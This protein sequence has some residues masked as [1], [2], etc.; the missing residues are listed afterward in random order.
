M[1]SDLFA[2]PGQ[3]IELRVNRS[4]VAI[5]SSHVNIVDVMDDPCLQGLILLLGTCVRTYLETNVLMLDM[6]VRH[7][8][9]IFYVQ[10]KL[11]SR[12]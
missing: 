11:T 4:I 3:S 10:F 12:V 9:R 2:R 8:I 5:P 1:V 6:R 7:K